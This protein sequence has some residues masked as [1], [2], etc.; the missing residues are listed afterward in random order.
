MIVSEQDSSFQP[1]GGPG[2]GGRI[3]LG[4]AAGSLDYGGRVDAFGGES[5]S[6]IGDG[7]VLVL[8]TTDLIIGPGASFNGYAPLSDAA[9]GSYLQT[10]LSLDNFI[11]TGG[12]G[13]AGEGGPGSVVP[14][15]RS[16]ALAAAAFGILMARTGRRRLARNEPPDPVSLPH[17]EV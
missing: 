9:E 1:S 10:D 17:K 3:I 12:G 2:G 5:P 14:E 16:W 8:V 7:G 6:S 13:G 15:P 4:S 11:L